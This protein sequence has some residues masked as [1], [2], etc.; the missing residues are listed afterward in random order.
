MTAERFCIRL[1][2]FHSA[3]FCQRNDHTDSINF[4]TFKVDVVKASKIEKV[5]MYL[6]QSNALKLDISPD[7]GLERQFALPSAKDSGSGLFERD[8]YCCSCFHLLARHR[9]LYFSNRL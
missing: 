9:L 4:V 7:F 8:W 5:S 6:R 2:A 1:Y 3:K